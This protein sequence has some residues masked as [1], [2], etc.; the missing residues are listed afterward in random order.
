[1]PLYCPST[2]GM[3]SDKT[4]PRLLTML[5]LV[6]MIRMASSRTLG[7]TES[8]T[9]RGVLTPTM[10]LPSASKLTRTTASPRTDDAWPCSFTWRKYSVGLIKYTSITKLYTKYD[11]YKSNTYTFHEKKA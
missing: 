5:P 8:S 6:L 7:G 11:F 1:M 4:C 10:T 9:I 3:A 2:A